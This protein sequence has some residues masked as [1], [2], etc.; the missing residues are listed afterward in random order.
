MLRYLDQVLK[1]LMPLTKCKCNKKYFLIDQQIARHFVHYSKCLYNP[2]P[3]NATQI[4]NP[5]LTSRI[6][7]NHDRG[8][9]FQPIV[10]SVY[11]LMF[12]Q[13]R[14]SFNVIIPNHFETRRRAFP[15]KRISLTFD[16]NL[17]NGFSVEKLNYSL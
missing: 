1:I 8:L 15:L 11:S 12:L 16:D 9:G 6:S 14:I 13:C 5:F 10:K 17:S 2:L 7:S 3:F 4:D